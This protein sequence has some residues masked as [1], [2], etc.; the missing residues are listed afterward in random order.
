M[1]IV[2]IVMPAAFASEA[3]AEKLSQDSLLLLPA[4]PMSRLLVRVVALESLVKISD[5][6]PSVSK[7]MTFF[8]VPNSFGRTG[9]P[10]SAL[11]STL[12]R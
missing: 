10:A 5:G 3:M 4:T 1:P 2:M 7:M 6:E 12:N 8:G 9:R 11:G